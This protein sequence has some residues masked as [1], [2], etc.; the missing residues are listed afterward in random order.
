MSEFP[1]LS[2]YEQQ[3]IW[4]ARM[5]KQFR[6]ALR[7]QGFGTDEGMNELTAVY[8]DKLLASPQPPL[9]PNIAQIYERMGSAFAA[10]VADQDRE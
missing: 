2:D 7:E 5:L 9:D 3:H 1:D 6:I 10:I 4:L 8:L